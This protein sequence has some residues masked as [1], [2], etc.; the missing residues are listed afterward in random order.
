MVRSGAL[1]RGGERGERNSKKGGGG[2]RRRQWEER[3]G[4][5]K[6]KRAREGE[7]VGLNE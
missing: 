1:G 7:D 4:W 2:A 6:V 5:T 3:E